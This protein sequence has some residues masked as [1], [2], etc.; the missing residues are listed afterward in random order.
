MFLAYR[1]FFIFFSTEGL[2]FQGNESQ[3]IVIITIKGFIKENFEINFLYHLFTLKTVKNHIWTFLTS[4][5]LLLFYMKVFHFEE[6][7]MEQGP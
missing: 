2:L 3:S 6:V 7:S 1:S 5:L 4:P